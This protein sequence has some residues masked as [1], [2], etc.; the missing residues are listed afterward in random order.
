MY[1][2]P[3]LSLTIPHL[4]QMGIL[5]KNHGQSQSCPWGQR[6]HHPLPWEGDW[7]CTPASAREKRT[8]QSWNCSGAGQ[9]VPSS[10]D[11]PLLL[12]SGSWVRRVRTGSDGESPLPWTQQIWLDLDSKA[13][14]SRVRNWKTWGES[15]V[16]PPRAEQ[17]LAPTPRHELGLGARP[18]LSP[19]RGGSAVEHRWLPPAP[20]PRAAGHLE[21]CRLRAPRL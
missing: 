6:I 11:S 14:H 2:Y 7:F 15:L 5:L 1:P 19:L 3:V 9:P 18:G 8:T 4:P 12:L 16:T 13:T 17:S 10:R 20:G 21:V